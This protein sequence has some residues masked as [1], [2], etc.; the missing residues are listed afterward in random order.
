V[1]DQFFGGG[2]RRRGRPGPVPRRGRD[3]ERTITLSFEQAIHGATLSLRLETGG[4]QRAQTLEVKVPP[5]VDEGRKI[6]VKGR[7]PGAN[8]GPPGDLILRCMIQPH[9]YFTRRGFDVYV[10]VPVSVVEAT[11]GAKVEVP[12]IDGC[13]VVTIPPGT[14]GG[15]KLRLSGGGVKRMDGDGRGDQ[16]VVIR[17]V[18]SKDL[19]EEQRGLFESLRE[20]DSSDPRASCAWNLGASA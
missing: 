8:G 16:Y 12:A 13:T 3:E 10:D 6:R 9:A 14:P 2:G 18:P 7:V 17:I 15:S 19:D 20:A 5:G 11:L 4:D 1:F